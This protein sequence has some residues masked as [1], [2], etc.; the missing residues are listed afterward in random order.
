MQQLKQEKFQLQNQLEVSEE[1]YIQKISDLQ[2]DI[3]NL[4]KALSKNPSDNNKTHSS[5]LVT[6]LTE[7][8]QRLAT[9]LRYSA[10]NEKELREQINN[11]RQ[12][13][14]NRKSS[15][16][17]HFD[18][19]DLLRKELYTVM[20]KK[21]ELEK[22][23]EIIS[24]EKVMMKQSVEKSNY[25]IS[26]LNKNRKKQECVFLDKEKD[27]EELR[28]R[29]NLLLRRLETIS[30]SGSSL[31][32]FQMSLFS[33]LEMS[34]S[35]QEKS[36][37]ITHFDIIEEVDEDCDIEEMDDSGCEMQCETDKEVEDLKKEVTNHFCQGIS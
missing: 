29:N 14:N 13:F 8:N 31:L 5:Q 36:C 20:E 15:I 22:M 34:C 2:A 21:S 6:D 3:A 33:E 12:Q 37:Q 19:A 10:E 16:Q 7:Q 18:H 35:D 25:K 26:E 23:L 11:L 1:E 4:R 17:E 28:V 9:Q 24:E 27:A 30:G 32:D